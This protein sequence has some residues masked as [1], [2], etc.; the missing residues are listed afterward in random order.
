MTDTDAVRAAVERL[1]RELQDGAASLE[2]AGDRE[3]PQVLRAKRDALADPTSTVLDHLID[4]LDGAG[5]AMQA[6]GLDQ[7]AH[8]LAWSV[9]DALVIQKSK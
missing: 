3:W 1:D 7:Q 5:K 8:K 2:A 6:A 4:A 9:L